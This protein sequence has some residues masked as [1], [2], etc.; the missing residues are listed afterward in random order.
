LRRRVLAGYFLANPLLQ[1]AS[2]VL[3]PFAIVTA[4]LIKAPIGM[5]LL[6]FTPLV[7]L[8]I[9]VLCQLVGLREFTRVYQS[10][11][12]PWHY[13]SV[14]LLAPLYQLLLGAAA[15]V[16]VYKYGKGDTRWY[17]TGRA[18]EHR[19]SSAVR[20]AQDEVAALQ[21]SI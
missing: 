6:M 18:A 11:A 13:A 12:R 4:L 10:S 16:A 1:A 14:L 3:L 2:A 19:V 5:T 20:S 7:P 9:T 21:P 8:G 17:K 15:A